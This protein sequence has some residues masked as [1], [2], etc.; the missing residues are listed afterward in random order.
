M[1]AAI[2]LVCFYF[3]VKLLNPFLHSKVLAEPDEEIN[4]EENCDVASDTPKAMRHPVHTV[5]DRQH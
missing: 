5:S 1:A 2:Y 3:L 4:E